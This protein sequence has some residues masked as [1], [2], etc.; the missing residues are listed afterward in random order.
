MLYSEY[1]KEYNRNVHIYGSQIVDSG[2]VLGAKARKALIDKYTGVIEDGSVLLG[3]KPISYVQ[4]ELLVIKFDVQV[5]VRNTKAGAG[6]LLKDDPTPEER[7]V[8]ADYMHIFSEVVS[9]N[10]DIDAMMIETGFNSYYNTS[11]SM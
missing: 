2:G 6:Y 7:R 4:D 5:L 10:M 3:V 9:G 11:E 1:V 8:C